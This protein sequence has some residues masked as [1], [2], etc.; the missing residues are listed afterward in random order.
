MLAVQGERPGGQSDARV[1]L[2]DGEGGVD[3]GCSECWR[4]AI[5]DD[6]RKQRPPL[7]S[8]LWDREER[9]S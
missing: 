2:R 6:M 1:R 7:G 3:R 4:A 8:W 9:G 5:Q